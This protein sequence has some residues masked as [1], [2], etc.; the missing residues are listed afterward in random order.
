MTKVS[1]VLTEGPCA[2][3]FLVNLVDVSIPTPRLPKIVQDALGWQGDA[4]VATLKTLWVAVE[5]SWVQTH[6]AERKMKM[7]EA[8]YDIIILFGFSSDGEEERLKISQ[9]EVTKKKA[10]A[11]F[12]MLHHDGSGFEERKRENPAVLV[13]KRQGKANKSV[14][15]IVGHPNDTAASKIDKTPNPM[16]NLIAFPSK[17]KD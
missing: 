1:P 15:A 9:P 4:N 17:I 6:M 16:A 3:C 7:S 10:F 8:L 2:G 5:A 11:M 12:Q 14:L 13:I